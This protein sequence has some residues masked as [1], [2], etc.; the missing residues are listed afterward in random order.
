MVKKIAVIV[1]GIL[2]AGLAVVL[3]LAL[4]KSD[5]F[6]V[7]RSTTIKAPPEKIFAVIGDFHRSPEWSPWE[8]MDPNIKRTYSGADSGKGAKYSWSGNDDVGEGSME[9]LEFYPP[10]KMLMN[11]HFVRPMGGDNTVEYVFEPQ[12]DL[13]KMTWSMHGPNNFTSKVMQVFMN[14]EQMVGAS[15]QEGLTSLKAICEK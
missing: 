4:T 6:R 9:I 3:C 14:C 8:K 13:T 7:E 12:G 15:F 2:L 1:G 10:T 5:E 11:L